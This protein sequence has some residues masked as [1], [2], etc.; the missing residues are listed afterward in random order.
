M[1]YFFLAGKISV[2]V[3]NRVVRIT[4]ACSGEDLLIARI[5]VDGRLVHIGDDKLQIW[6]V[7]SEGCKVIPMVRMDAT[8]RL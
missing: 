2:I 3:G 4:A 1:G 5:F 6:K 7:M 8:V